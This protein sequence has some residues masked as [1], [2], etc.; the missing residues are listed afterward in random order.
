[1]RNLEKNCEL[2]PVTS[3][4]TVLNKTLV[5]SHIEITMIRSHEMIQFDVICDFI[6]MNY[7]NSEEGSP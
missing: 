1:M 2:H 3:F 5:I 7:W 6:I 4:N